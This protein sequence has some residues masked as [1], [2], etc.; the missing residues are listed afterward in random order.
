MGTLNV[1]AGAAAPPRAAW[2][3][4]NALARG[5]L[6]ILDQGMFA[7]ANFLMS[8]LLARW[9]SPRWY[10]ALTVAQATAVLLG[11]LHTALLSEPMMVYGSGLFAG[12][13]GR[14]IPPLLR[15]HLLGT[16][17]AA[18]VVALAGAALRPWIGQEV[19]TLL[20]VLAASLPAMFPLFIVRRAYYVRNSPGW[21]AMTS[22]LYLVLTVAAIV[23][24]RS[25]GRLT[26][27]VA[28]AAGAIISLVVASVFL[29]PLRPRWPAD[30]DM[31]ARALAPLH[32]R[33]GRWAMGISV[34]I[35]LS[36]W[37]C[38]QLLPPWL[39]LE[40]VA[41]LR[42]AMNLV[43][44]AQQVIAALSLLMLPRL[45]G[46]LAGGG[47]GAAGRIVRRFLWV[48]VTGAAA[49]LALLAWLGPWAMQQLYSGRYPQLGA[50]VAVA[51]L[52]PLS[53]AV[54]T[55]FE[56]ALRAAQRVRAAFW[57]NV[58]RAA[59]TLGLV[60]P[61]GGWLGLKAVLVGMSA[62]SAASAALIV[63]AYAATLGRGGAKAGR[64]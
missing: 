54:Y 13:L 22:G 3:V 34:L 25:A 31:T 21:A 49:Y 61:L 64:P 7:G 26:A 29:W 18:G 20:W 57:C 38:Y 9:L 32:W 48:F 1:K 58:A 62:A 8:I 10:G 45:V 23:A 33:Y 36:G 47:P 24:L 11:S 46:A 59:L 40:G 53:M 14:Y 35:W 50:W 39:G 30:A 27:P 19:S 55:P 17:A 28:M 16:A 12:R 44:P 5:G 2:A 52:L 15:L 4:P 6:T 41:A 42:A 63:V 51:G 37:A 43:L 60:V 56:M